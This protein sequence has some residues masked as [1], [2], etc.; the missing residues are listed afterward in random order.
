M[1]IHSLTLENVKSYRR[2]TVEFSPGTNAIIGS[3]GSGKTTILEAIGFALFNHR[4]GKLTAF[5]REG[6][7]LASV[8]LE[9][10]SD[11]DGRS[12]QIL[13][14]CGSKNLYRVDDPELSTRVC[15]GRTDF[16]Q[17]LHQHLGIDPETDPSEFFRNAVGVPQGTSTASFLLSPSARKAVFDP[18]LKV[19][20]YRKAFDKLREPLNLLRQR[21]VDQ[22]VQISRLEGELTRL[23]DAKAEAKSLRSH[24]D[25]ADNELRAAAK[26]FTAA[27]S[28]R[29][30]M[31]ARRERLQELGRMVE[32]QQQL[33]AEQER[34]LAAARQ[35]FTESKEAV[36]VTDAS[37]AGHEAYRASLRAQQAMNERIAQR[38]RLEEEQAG[39]RT[40]LAR[41]ETQADAQEGALV[42]I[43]GAEKTAA[44]LAD[45][46]TE[47]ERL[48]VEFH[49]AQRLADRLKDANDR[50]QREQT[51]VEKAQKRLD[52]L[53]VEVARSQKLEAS[54][55]QLQTQVETLQQTITL[56]ESICSQLQ[57]EME[58]IKEQG[59][60]LKDLDADAV[61]PICEQP[62]SAEHR[63]QLLER[64]RQRW[65]EMNVRAMDAAETIRQAEAK[66]EQARSTLTKHEQT[67]HSLPRQHAIETAEK[68]LADQNAQYAEARVEAEALRHMPQRVEQLQQALKALGDPRRQ[69]DAALQLARGR[70]RVERSLQKQRA[71][72]E[73]QRNALAE[74]DGRMAKFAG[75]DA[76]TAHISSQLAKFQ[77]ADDLYRRNQAAAEALPQRLQEVSDAERAF[78]T[79]QKRL[80]DGQEQLAASRRDFDDERF[81]EVVAQVEE[82]RSRCVQLETE[83]GQW[84]ERL[85]RA[86]EEIAQLQGL[87]G[88]LTTARTRHD[89]LAEQEEL[90]RFLRTV[91]R[92]AGPFVTKA[93]VQQISY[94]ANQLF[95]Q[96]M[97]DYTRMLRWEEDYGIILEVD[98][99]DRAFPQLS[100]GEQMGAALAVRLA[101]LQ[102]MSSIG[103]AFFDEPTTNLDETR[104]GSLARQIV[105]VRGFEQ[106][107]IIS[108]DD[109]FEQATEKL[110]RVEKRNGASEILYE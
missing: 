37:R 96:I 5:V 70:E 50:V 88:R 33:V 36:A 110:I 49:N 89:R 18:L 64:L 98:G 76:E 28:T 24:I 85:D 54:R 52:H 6:R 73:Q 102:E 84:R 93:L 20:E 105:G 101:L 38:R 29:Q 4:P 87:E 92:E 40:L 86:K 14:C 79:A 53:R 44:D 91:L 90:L 108:H 57:P 51:S 7:Q 62:L 41:A 35:W 3:N 13:R 45:A 63:L 21:Q 72:A 75:L 94:S 107:F 9:F 55:K 16:I 32:V 106:L 43:E 80:E 109:S 81:Q 66:W 60:Q 11:Y 56:Q 95:G 104:R 68:E 30:V 69:R 42:E 58:T 59:T 12:Y 67:L 8:T 34:T 99:R 78:D 82:I 83:L 77:S 100:G 65:K 71:Q 97:E 61:C 48:D 74:L 19:A 26:E 17:F 1:L 39:I 103:V 25:S 2:E 10:L 31:E 23:P 46:A 47:Q 27:D 22:A 15:E